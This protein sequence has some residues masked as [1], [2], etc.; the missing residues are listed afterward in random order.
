MRLKEQNSWNQ[1]EADWRRFLL[2]EPGL[3]RRECKDRNAAESETRKR[4]DN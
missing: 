3:L 4:H 2:M 1:L